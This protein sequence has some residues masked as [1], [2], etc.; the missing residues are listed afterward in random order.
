MKNISLN[1]L[2]RARVTPSPDRIAVIG[3]DE[4][5]CFS[6]LVDVS[7][8][9]HG[10]RVVIY[11]SDTVKFIRTLVSL[12]GAAKALCPI[13]TLID[14]EELF[15]LLS[16]SEFDAVVSDL[17]EVNLG[18]FSR[19]NITFFSTS[20]MKFYDENNSHHGKNNSTWFIPTSGTTSR[21]KLVTH[22]LG[23]LAASSLKSKKIRSSSEVWGQFYDLTRYAG[24]Q[25]L[26]NSLLNGHT[27]V[28]SSFD[29]PIQD[30][31]KNCAEKLVTHI[32][33][34][35]SQ[36]R[37]ILMTGEDAKRIPLKQIVLGGEAADQPLLNALRRH[38]SEAK[39]TH[40][41]ASTE[42]GLGISVSDGLAG[43]PSRFL[44]ASEGSVNI[45][46][47]DDKL[48][49]RTL[50]SASA[51][52]DGRE[53]KD[54]QGWIETGDLVKFEGDRFFIIGREN[55]TINVGGD[56]VNPEY[57]RHVLLTHPSIGQVSVYGKK[58][59]I[60]GMVLA[61]DIQLMP[62]VDEKLANK[63]IKLFIKEKFRPKDQPRIIKMVD[64]I[65]ISLSGKLGPNHDS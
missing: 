17:N 32:S 9:M 39:I 26:F 27:L 14:E 18:V 12:D 42:A 37:Q 59:S 41:Y 30:R 16:Q 2:I 49:L 21:P 23:S 4:S 64:D 24:Y 55:G 28:T 54:S 1:N 7:S 38:F 36:W 8:S 5:L 43:F 44:D 19:L 50:S 10:Q 56:K 52:S 25:V 51:Y 46:I 13:S 3:K 33:A 61:A 20:E 6:D 15:D 63:S 60:T 58:N 40:T 34:T 48:F 29:Q 47:R 22:E 53:L 11:I 35:P 31:V 57:V 45:S 65:Q 62:D